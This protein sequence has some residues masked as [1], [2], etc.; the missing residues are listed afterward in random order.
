MLVGD[1]S[2][3]ERNRNVR[4]CYPPVSTEGTLFANK[5][6]RNPLPQKHVWIIYQAFRV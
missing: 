1:E 4:A 6:S 2:G 5:E 3:G